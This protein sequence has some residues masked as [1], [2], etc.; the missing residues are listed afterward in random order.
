MKRTFPNKAT[1]ALA[2]AL[3]ITAFMPGVGSAVEMTS[4]NY[5]LSPGM[6]N[7]GGGEG[8]SANYG[9]SGTLSQPVA[10]S[11]AGEAN[12]LSAGFWNSGT[13]GYVLP[14][15]TAA[16]QNNAAY[17]RLSSVDVNLTAASGNGAIT[18]VAISDDGVFDSEPW[19]GY[20]ATMPW[21]LPAGDGAKTV[22]VRFRDASGFVSETIQDA[23]TLD[24][25]NPTDGTLAAGPQNTVV[26][27]SWTGFTD[28]TSG[29]DTYSVRFDTATTP[30]DC[31]S[32]T[33]AYSGAATS[34]LHQSLANGTPYYYRICATDAAGNTS[35]G[36]L[37][38][39]TP[40]AP[41]PD[42]I[43][44]AYDNTGLNPGIGDNL[45]GVNRLGG[46]DDDTNTDPGTGKMK[47]DTEYGFEFVLKDAAG[48]PTSVTAYLTQRSAPGPADYIAYALDPAT[49]CTGDFTL[50][51][52][53]TFTTRLGPSSVHGF[54]FEAELAGGGTERYPPS[55]DLTGP[56]VKLLTGYNMLGVP[57]VISGAAL[58][59]TGAFGTDTTWRWVS[60][61]LSSGATN[62]GAYEQVDELANPGVTKLTEGEG[63]FV[64]NTVGA[65]DVLDEFAAYADITGPLTIVLRPGW[66]VIS[67]P[68]VGNVPLRD[69]EVV[70]N[71]DAPV[72]WTDATTNGWFINGIYYYNGS[73]W[74]STY[75]S[76]SSGGAV[77]ATLTPW[78]SYWVYLKKDAAA[79]TLIVNKP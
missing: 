3:S 37:A 56:T 77:E 41:V 71:S 78:L 48:T 73:D 29:L 28:A 79:Y 32:G 18:D 38:S 35:A 76:E 44:V 5:T 61:G 2:L 10:G 70:K 8:T 63:Y 43:S 14:T 66:N 54:Y 17:T 11:T 6:T 45:E 52:A 68:Y 51:A 67:N 7:G 60:T 59:G 34:I 65:P 47:V 19:N 64:F 15:G 26:E 9:L 69:V 21:T 33:E 31:A 22:Y 40:A 62:Y 30:A 4:P 36:A 13:L 20:S 72:T 46:G 75:T 74:G 49:D 58:D 53:C 39:A 55:G 24:G 50:G 16:I 27:L 42:G 57:R 23:I 25:T 12:S 1:L